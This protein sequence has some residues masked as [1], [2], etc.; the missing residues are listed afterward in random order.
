VSGINAPFKDLLAGTDLYDYVHYL[1]MKSAV[2]GIRNSNE[3]TCPSGYPTGFPC[4]RPSD[5][6]TRLDF[7]RAVVVAQETWQL[8]Q[9]SSPTFA[10]IPYDNYMYK[11]V[12]T[13]AG[14]GMIGGY[15]CGGV[16]E[17]CDAQSRPYFRP[18]A[19]LTRGQSVKVITLAQKWS[20]A[21][22]LPPT[23]ADV[24]TNNT[25]YQYV[26]TAYLYKLIGGYTCGGANEPCDANNRPYFRPS[27]P[28][29][30]SQAAKMT[31]LMDQGNLR[32]SQV[33]SGTNNWDSNSSIS[34]E[35]RG[36]LIGTVPATSNYKATT[37]SLMWTQAAKTW[38]QNG[39]Y[40]S[41]IVYHAFQANSQNCGSSNY[42]GSSATNN[43]SDTYLPE[44]KTCTYN[45]TTRTY[46]IRF[47]VAAPYIIGN[48]PGYYATVQFDNSSTEKSEVV[49]SN[50]YNDPLNRKKDDMRKFCFFQ[51]EVGWVEFG[52]ALCHQ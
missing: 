19:T 13:A 2:W 14:R 9:P 21:Y 33:Y 43:F 31:Y 30:R 36:F 49:V 17:P 12:E 42:V 6:M 3:G 50:Y 10:D 7:V 47:R 40:S 22:P 26:E 51:N 27:E 25:F 34:T 20:L 1:C 16:G 38:L 46:E 48:V 28:V 4:F 8:I 52:T 35:P 11:F 24:D 29:R 41:D 5:Y 37:K 15:P 39:S 44:L 45:S 23:F 18:N 32:H